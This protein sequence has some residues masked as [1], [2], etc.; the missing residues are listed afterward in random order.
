MD[1]LSNLGM[2][3]G[4]VKAASL[5]TRDTNLYIMSTVNV[6]RLLLYLLLKPKVLCRSQVVMANWTFWKR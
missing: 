5:D 4:P 3:S 2:S 6:Y 1:W